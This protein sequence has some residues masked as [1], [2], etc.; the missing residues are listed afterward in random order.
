MPLGSSRRERGEEFYVGAQ[1]YFDALATHYMPYLRVMA[2]EVIYNQALE[3]TISRAESHDFHWM[4]L[5][6]QVDFP[7]T[8]ATIQLRSFCT[9]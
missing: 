7:R 5:L 6:V 4:E 9:R 2:G 3:V 1:G 8:S